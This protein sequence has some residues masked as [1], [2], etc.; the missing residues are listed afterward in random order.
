MKT[1][2]LFLFTVIF[3]FTAYFP[4]NSV[5]QI[6]NKADSTMFYIAPGF[7]NGINLN[8]IVTNPNLYKPYTSVLFTNINISQNSAPQNEPSVKISRKNPN[9]VVTAWRDFRFGVDPAAN[10]RIGYSYSTDTGATWSVPIILDS[11]LIPGEPRNSDPVIGVDSAGN[12]YIGVIA[13]NITNSNGMLVIYKSTDG[14]VTFPFAYIA[15]SSSGTGEDKEYITTDLTPG[16][17]YYNTI[18]F[19]WTRFLTGTRILCIKSTNGGV[20]WSTPVP[21]SEATSGV[22]GSDPVISANGQVNV[23]WLSNNGTT[24]SIYYDKSTDG[25]IT[26]GTDIIISSGTSPTGLPNSASTF[27]SIAADI[28]GGPRNGYLYA[29]FSDSRNGDPDVFLCRSTNSGNNWSS[30]VR[31]NNDGIANGKLQFWPWISV[32]DSGNI[33]IIWYDTRNTANNTIVEAYLAR[34]VNGGLTFTNE[35]LSSQPS[36]TNVPGSS[37]RFGDYI[38]V[39]YWKNKIVPVWTDERAG[40]T[41]MEIYT[42]VINTVVG[43]APVSTKIPDEFKLEQNYPNPFNPSTNIKYQIKAESSSQKSEVRMIVYDV[44]GK[45]IVTLV[46]EKQSP[47]TYEVLFDGNNLPSGIYFYRLITEGFS[48]TKKMI[49]IK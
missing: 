16:S 30:P 6:L 27:P 26:F 31:V 41:D 17:P 21:V 18:Y 45:E 7:N 47:G 5:A 43:I 28:S 15:A 40:G 2:I 4:S 1:G 10:R 14:G 35:L 38:C 42:A 8:T 13:L 49:L 29:V 34:S 23:V 20:N 11:T 19:T 12:F 22:Q 9:R 33:A 44:L 37:V 24:S 25:G 32:N 46:N 48:D 39:D 36:P 3:L